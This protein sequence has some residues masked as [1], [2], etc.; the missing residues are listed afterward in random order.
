MLYRTVL[1]KGKS[2]LYSVSK[3]I[4]SQKERYLKNCKHQFVYLE[5][6]SISHKKFGNIENYPISP[7]FY[8]WQFLK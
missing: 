6:I 2:A 1:W 5:M 4:I 8:V 3:N 7:V